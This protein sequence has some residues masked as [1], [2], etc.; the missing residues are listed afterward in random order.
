M[1]YLAECEY[2]LDYSPL[3]TTPVRLS[4]FGRTGYLTVP[5]YLCC[6][7]LLMQT[8]AQEGVHIV[9]GL[10]NHMPTSLPLLNGLPDGEGALGK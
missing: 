5:Y 10:R 3:Y 6:F 7:G 8:S 9:R 4:F 2:I 1:S